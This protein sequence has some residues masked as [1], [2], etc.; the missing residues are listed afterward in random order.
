MLKLSGSWRAKARK[1]EPK[2]QG[3]RPKRPEWLDAEGKKAW[4]QLTPIL[5]RMRVLT[6]ADGFA[7]AVLCESWS[8]YRRATDMLIQYGDVYPV[9][10]PDGT[11]KMLR[12]SPYSAM[13][14]E[15]ALNVRRMLAEFGLTPAARGRLIALPEDKDHGKAAYFSRGSAAG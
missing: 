6:E 15:L 9:K 12:R 3:T 2:P 11:L 10:N 5:E 7:L 4:D 8:R 13:Q 1:D 14:M